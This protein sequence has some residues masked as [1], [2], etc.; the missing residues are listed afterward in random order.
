LILLPQPK[1]CAQ[2]FTRKKRLDLRPRDREKIIAIA[3][4]HL[5]PGAA[6]WVFGS[7]INSTAH[8]TSD[9]DLVIK[10]PAQGELD[11]S[12]GRDVMIGD[13]RSHKT[14]S[15]YQTISDQHRTRGE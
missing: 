8:S 3:K 12:A 6:V 13:T 5:P 1:P 15:L 10:E 4:K 7:R 14:I 9:V 11:F 2:P